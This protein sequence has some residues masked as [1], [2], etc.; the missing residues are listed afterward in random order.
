MDAA[1]TGQ[2]IAV[3]T[4]DPDSTAYPDFS[5]VALRAGVRHLVSMGMP[6]NQRVVGG[7]NIYGS[8]DVPFDGAAVE[9]M[10]TFAGY[11][12]VAVSNAA[13]YHDAV[14]LASQLQTA[15][16]SRSV[17][18][19]AK[20]MIMAERRCDA[21][22]AFRVLTRTSQTQNMKLRR[23]AELLIERRSATST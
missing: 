23:V 5:K 21:D 12:A 6:M 13:N 19:Q 4:R 20:G 3:D 1:L 8:E 9:V 7:L 2:M 10:Q 11:A 17:I 14:G 16:Q 18:E 15:M 22:T